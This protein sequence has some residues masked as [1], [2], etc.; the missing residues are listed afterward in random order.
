MNRRSFISSILAAA[1]APMV[2][3][4]ALR[5]W[6]KSASSELLAPK[7][8]F[9]PD[10]INA[11]YELGIIFNK[12]TVAKHVLYNRFEEFTKDSLVSN[13]MINDEF[14]I[15]LDS[16]LKVIQNMMPFKR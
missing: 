8:E 4:G 5:V 14:P 9:N 2:L 16:N 7:W 6:K 1:T 15:R 13:G 11:P 12:G 10:W 3:P